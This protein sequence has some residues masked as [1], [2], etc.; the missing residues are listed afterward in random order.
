MTRIWITAEF[1]PFG[2]GSS[3]VPRCHCNTDSLC[4]PEWLHSRL[5]LCLLSW[6]E[7]LDHWVKFKLV[8]SQ[9]SS[10]WFRLLNT[11]TEACGMWPPETQWIFFPCWL[12]KQTHG[13]GPWTK[14]NFLFQ[15][16]GRQLMDLPIKICRILLW[17]RSWI[18][19]TENRK[20]DRLIFSIF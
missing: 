14:T 11:G 13:S 2:M 10:S 12:R 1:M 19:C 9:S 4:Q 18:L 3:L 20:K 7:S 5:S 8:L 16:D 15:M 17:N 6:S